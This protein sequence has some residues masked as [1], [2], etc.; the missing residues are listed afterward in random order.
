MSHTASDRWDSTTFKGFG[1]SLDDVNTSGLTPVFEYDT[2]TGNCSGG[3]Y[4]ARQFA[5]TEDSQAAQQIFSSTTVADEHNLYVCY[6]AVIS[7]TQSAGDY[8]NHVIY[9]ATATF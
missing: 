1:F 2:T 9:T 3:T 4:C 7:S 5:D 6:R 8:E